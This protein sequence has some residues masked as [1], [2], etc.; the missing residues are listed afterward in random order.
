MAR[1]AEFCCSDGVILT[2]GA[3]GLPVDRGE[4]ERVRVGCQLPVV[5]GSGATIDNVAG[6]LA[7]DA[8]IVGSHFKAGGDWRGELERGRVARFME[9][10]DS[11][12]Q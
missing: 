3:T 7:A 11:L 9:K 4:V 1:G 12:R 10:V 2:G 5:V 6:Y 8:L